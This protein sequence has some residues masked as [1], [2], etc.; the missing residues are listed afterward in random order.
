MTKLAALFV[1][2]MVFVSKG[3]QLENGAEKG[4]HL[5]KATNKIAESRI[6]VRETA[7]RNA[8]NILALQHCRR[9]AWSKS[10]NSKFNKDKLNYFKKCFHHLCR[11]HKSS[12]YFQYILFGC[13]LQ[14]SDTSDWF[15]AIRI[16]TKPGHLTQLS[17][18]IKA[19]NTYRGYRND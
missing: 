2:K 1:K 3:K 7:A 8:V 19:K 9:Q 13:K 4:N 10:S 11:I 15:Y 14:F 6:I 12:Q 5:T 16:K 17:P 18:T